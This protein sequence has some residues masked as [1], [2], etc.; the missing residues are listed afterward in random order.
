[1]IK[2]IVGYLCNGAEG[3]K[4]YLKI[5]RKS[6]ISKMKMMTTLPPTHFLL[7]YNFSWHRKLKT[8]LYVCA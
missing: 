1:M 3:V 8:V 2:D 4:A 6:F 7:S 5:K